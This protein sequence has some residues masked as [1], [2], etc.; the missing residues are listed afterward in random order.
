MQETWTKQINPI[1]DESCFFAI[2]SETLNKQAS[3]NLEERVIDLRET[4]GEEFTVDRLRKIYKA[5]KIKKKP[6][7]VALKSD[8]PSN[9]SVPKR[10]EERRRL[11]ERLDYCK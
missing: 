1:S 11:F 2:K 9:A 6:V 3:M 10:M 4:T 8:L 5:A 7:Q